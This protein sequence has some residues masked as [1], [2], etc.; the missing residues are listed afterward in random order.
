MLKGCKEDSVRFVY[1]WGT[2]TSPLEF[3]TMDSVTKLTSIIS[4]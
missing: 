2:D 1:V 4:D 3:V